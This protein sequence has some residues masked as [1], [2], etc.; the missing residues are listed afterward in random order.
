MSG[1]P[2]GKAHS[3]W[4]MG[5]VWVGVMLTSGAG[6][7][8]SHRGHQV[9]QVL[10]LEGSAARLSP[11]PGLSFPICT[12]CPGWRDCASVSRGRV[13]LR[14]IALVLAISQPVQG[15]AAPEI[16]PGRAGGRQGGFTATGRPPPARCLLRAIVTW[17]PSLAILGPQGPGSG[18]TVA[19]AVD[20]P[21]HLLG[22]SPLRPS[23]G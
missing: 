21:C 16:S 15:P 7:T 2:F 18:C 9:A 6:V 20:P 13:P 3:L 17:G 4:L 19:R 14:D 1:S 22:S 8:R 23:P 5:K 10:N 12:L 11:S